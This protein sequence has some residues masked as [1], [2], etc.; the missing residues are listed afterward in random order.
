MT[1]VIIRFNGDVLNTRIVLKEHFSP[2]LLTQP[3]LDNKKA[4]ALECFVH[5]YNQ[6]RMSVGSPNLR[7]I[8]KLGS[9]ETKKSRFLA[10]CEFIEENDHLSRPSSL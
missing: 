9:N 3:S 8:P 10:N 7:T 1:Y 6:E 2:L 5:E 4:Y